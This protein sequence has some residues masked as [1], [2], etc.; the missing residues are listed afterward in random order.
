VKTGAKSTGIRSRT[1]PVRAQASTLAGQRFEKLV[2]LQARLRGPGG[3][4]WDAE[5]THES[6]RT[7][8]IEEAYETLDA[9]ESGTRRSLRASWAICCCR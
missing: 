7:F 4:P 8:L 9:L 3:C 5:Q 1:N 2:A 6:L